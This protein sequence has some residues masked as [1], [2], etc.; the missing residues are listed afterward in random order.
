MPSLPRLYAILDIDT[1]TARGLD[2]RAVLETWL[3]AGVRL[4]QLR[5][6]SLPG[7]P[8]L[9]LAET[10]A[11]ACHQ[12]GA[13]FI[14]NDRAD[15]AR[16]CG[17]DGVHVGQRDLGPSAARALC[18]PPAVVG[19][20]THD[21]ET[22]RLGLET[23]ADYLA[24]GPVFPTITK[25]DADPAVG[26]DGVARAAALAG[27]RPMVAIGGITLGNAP[28]VLGAGAASVAVVSDLL[29]GDLGARARDFVAICQ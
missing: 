29:V 13:L 24:I 18:P 16:L 15:I 9:S 21:D 2:P 23:P 10:L 20:S 8:M 11:G 3:G 12:A 26:L 19:L 17:A 27:S 14:I 22:V 6:K 7:G 4:I 28:A 1:T 25:A 5:A